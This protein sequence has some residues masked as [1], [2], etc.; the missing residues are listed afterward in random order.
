MLLIN[1]CSAIGQSFPFPTIKKYGKVIKD[2]IPVNWFIKD[3]CFGD[4][5]NDSSPDLAFVI[6][7][8]DTIEESRPDSSINT[9]SPR[10]LI[11]CLKNNTTGLFDLF[12]QNNTF[13]YRYGEGGMDPDP[14][15]KIDISNKVLTISYIY[16]RGHADYKFRY[17]NKDFFLIGA[18]DGGVD[19]GQIDFWDFNFMT[20]KAKHEWGD[21]SSEKM[22]TKWVTLSFKK[23]RRLREMSIPFSWEILPTVFI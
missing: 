15:N 23:L 2:F 1:V 10:V 13:I 12:I 20:K 8:K 14:Y 17:Q 21:M 18:E 11:V 4:L 6:Q 19:G 3:S 7:F 9:G 16:T 22:N 5:N